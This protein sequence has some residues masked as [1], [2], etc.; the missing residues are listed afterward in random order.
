MLIPHILRAHFQH[1]RRRSSTPIH[2]HASWVQKRHTNDTPLA[3]ILAVDG[4]RAPVRYIAYMLHC[5]SIISDAYSIHSP[6]IFYTYSIHIP[7]IFHTSC[8]HIPCIGHTF[9]YI[10]MHIPYIFQAYSTQSDHIPSIF[11]T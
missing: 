10:F 7:G 9:S 11:H 4:Q 5:F 8:I 2:Y 3:S 6:C 1:V